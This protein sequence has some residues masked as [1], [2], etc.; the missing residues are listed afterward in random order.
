MG[1]LRQGAAMRAPQVPAPVQLK[2]KVKSP[3]LFSWVG[4]T[5]V[6]AAPLGRWKDETAK[7]HN[8]VSHHLV[9]C[10]LVLAA[11]RAAHGMGPQE[12]GI[13]ADLRC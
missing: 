7:A 3:F 11:H 8:V 1:K 2:D 13:G 10:K 5:G 4:R 12:S 6:P 9:H